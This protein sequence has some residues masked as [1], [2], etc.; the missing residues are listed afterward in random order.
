MNVF[1]QSSQQYYSQKRFFMGQMVRFLLQNGADPS[2]VTSRGE[3]AAQLTEDSDVINLLQSPLPLATPTTE[4]EKEELKRRAV[5][6][7]DVAHE[8]VTV[9]PRRSKKARVSSREGQSEE[10]QE[11]EAEEEAEERSTSGI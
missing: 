8:E 1:L 4:E 2:A 11:A 5:T 6:D 10:K 9:T 3:T 7:D